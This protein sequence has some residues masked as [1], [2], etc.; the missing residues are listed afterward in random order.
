MGKDQQVASILDEPFEIVNFGGGEGVLGC[1]DD[2]KMGF[3]DLFEV[4]GFLIESDLGV[5]HSYLE[6]LLV[7]LQEFLE[8]RTRIAH[9]LLA[10]VEY[11]L[12]STA[13]Y[14]LLSTHLLS[15]QIYYLKFVSYKT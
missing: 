5:T 2:E 12:E 9:L 11:Y 1:S 8:V 7:F 4:D 6:A 10:R 14:H 3:F 13:S 15:F